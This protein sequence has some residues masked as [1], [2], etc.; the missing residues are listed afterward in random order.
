[1]TY[2]DLEMTNGKMNS[3]GAL[4]M[5]IPYC[6]NEDVLIPLAGFLMKQ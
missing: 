1:M 5:S 6:V 3:T 2:T 4:G